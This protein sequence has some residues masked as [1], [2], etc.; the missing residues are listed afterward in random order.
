MA[1]SNVSRRMP[2]CCMRSLVE[3]DRSSRTQTTRDLR[4]RTPCIGGCLDY[5]HG[6]H[7]VDLGI[8]TSY[9]LCARP[10]QLALGARTAFDANATDRDR[11]RYNAMHSKLHGIFIYAE[12][13]QQTLGVSLATATVTAHIRMLPALQRPKRIDRPAW[14]GAMNV[15]PPLRTQGT[16]QNSG[17]ADKRATSHPCAGR[18]RFRTE[19]PAARR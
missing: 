8:L 7:D 9:E 13:L 5:F 12:F 14:P 10:L 15:K 1:V 11:Y 3:P 2:L 16:P 18:M 6:Y 4:S 19:A 17:S